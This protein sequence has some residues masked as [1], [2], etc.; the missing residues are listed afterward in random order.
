MAD[1]P[2]SALKNLSPRSQAALRE[3]GV[4]TL[5]AAAELCDEGLLEIEGVG[6]SSVKRI[7]DW[8]AGLPEAASRAVVRVPG[9]PEPG[10][11]DQQEFLAKM[12]G[13]H[14]AGGAETDEAMRLAKVDLERFLEEVAG[15]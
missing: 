11:F 12:Y 3:A 5:E 14:R 10:A 4:H 7:R 13:I 2:L 9:S 6:P 15:V 1:T 8:Q